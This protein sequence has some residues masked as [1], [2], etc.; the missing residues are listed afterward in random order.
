[1]KNRKQIQKKLLARGIQIGFHYQPNH[2]LSLY[3]DDKSKPLPVIDKLFPEIIS[4]PLHPNLTKENVKNVAIE[5]IKL[6]CN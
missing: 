1:M 4:L 2:W 6:I 3:K 5:L